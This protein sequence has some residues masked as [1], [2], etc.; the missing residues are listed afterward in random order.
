MKKIISS[1]TFILLFI[2]LVC[3]AHL[4]T[5]QENNQN[6]I[7]PML[8]KVTPAV[9]N[10][11]VEEEQLTKLNTLIPT[12]DNITKVPVKSY[13]VGSG[14]IF[15]AEKGLIVTNAHVVAHEKV[16]IVTLKDG[17]RYHAKLI[18]KAKGYDIA[19]LA[20][21]AKNLTALKF[22]NSDNVKVGDFVTA[23]GSPYGLSQT[24]T[25]GVVSALNRT[26]PRIE[27]YQSFIQT[28][29]P[30]NPGNSGGALV[31]M[32]GDLIGINTAMVAPTDGSI[33]LGFSIPSNMVK[34]VI[35]QLLKY[36]KVEH[37]VLGV[38][39]QNITPELATAL[40]LKNTKGAI[41]SE[42]VPNTPAATAGLKVGDVITDIDNHPVHGAVQ[43]KNT[44]GLIRPGTSAT[45]TLIRDHKTE[46]LTAIVANPKTLKE[47]EVPYFAGMRLQ[48]FNELESDGT[49]LHGVIVTGLTDAS[50]G[51]LAGLL[52]GDVIT[53]INNTPIDSIETLQ[54]AAENQTKPL[55]LDVTRGKGN[56]FLVLS[57]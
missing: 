8:A 49:K 2:P 25:S 4:P 57:K 43:L 39:V 17:E 23:I 36:G 52:P 54:K 1:I 12:Q 32:Q 15:D 30:I 16:I 11:Y 51:A 56:V 3:L 41:I 27:G 22:A 26:H 37:G 9:V 14:V 24:V 6:T 10:I 46:T 50:N 33:G 28:D 18:A 31:D 21:Q 48:K 53:S 38:I 55:L 34:G 13:A 44:M 47:K 5:T 35:E 7:A 40:N 20:I 42:I 29:A 45:I 19:I